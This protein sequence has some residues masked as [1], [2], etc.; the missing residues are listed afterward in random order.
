M[1]IL[2]DPL[3]DVFDDTADAPL[4]VPARDAGGNL[5]KLWAD[6]ADPRWDVNMTFTPDGHLLCVRSVTF[7]E[8]A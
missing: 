3:A 2:T 6:P 8:V 5:L 1:S 4:P 7:R